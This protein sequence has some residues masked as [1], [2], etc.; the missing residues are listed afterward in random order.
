MASRE[1]SEELS[2]FSELSNSEDF[3]NTEFNPLVQFGWRIFDKT[4]IS[5]PLPLKLMEG[6]GLVDPPVTEPKFFR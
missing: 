1:P 3:S 5:A 4:Q 6:L 2:D